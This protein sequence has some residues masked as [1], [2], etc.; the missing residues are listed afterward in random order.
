MYACKNQQKTQYVQ[1]KS[2]SQMPSCSM[3]AQLDFGLDY[4]GVCCISRTAG[5]RQDTCEGRDN[6][7]LTQPK[8]NG[9]TGWASIQSIPD[10]AHLLGQTGQIC[11]HASVQAVLSAV[12][13]RHGQI[14]FAHNVSG[15]VMIKVQH[16]ILLTT[17]SWVNSAREGKSL[18]GIMQLRHEIT[19]P[20]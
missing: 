16:L 8:A 13:H 18:R 10:A 17:C 11:D 14:N 5:P 3:Q 15:G 7:Q 20:A 2:G 9:K 19:A 4:I 12:L 1:L 6:A